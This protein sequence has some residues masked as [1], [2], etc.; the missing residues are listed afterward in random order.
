MTRN[1]TFLHERSIAAAMIAAMTL[2]LLAVPSAARAAT[3][4]AASP[5]ASAASASASAAVPLAPKGQLEIQLWPSATS[6]SLVVSLQLPD[7]AALP[8]RVRIPL[9]EGARVTWA[10]EITGSDAAK[11]IPRSFTTISVSGGRAIEFVAENVRNLQY[12]ADLPAPAVAGGQVSTT[13]A[14]VQTTDALGVNPAVKTPAGAGGV[15]ITPTPSQQP[16]TNS[17]GEALYTLPQEHLALGGGFTMQVSFIQ[18]VA[19]STSATSTASAARGGGA[20]VLYVL[21]AI[22][23]LVAVVVVVLALRSA[24][25]FGAVRDDSDEDEDDQG[26]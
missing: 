13:L 21:V 1:A 7:T 11:D 2:S 19:G 18:G 8:A 16:R 14:W 22:L 24:V 12:E 6:S 5:A 9:P 25:T 23:V 20:T 3:K 10:G 15:K 26:E 4:P 17:L